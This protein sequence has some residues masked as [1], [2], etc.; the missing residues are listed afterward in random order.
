MNN[1]EKYGTMLVAT[2]GAIAGGL[3]TYNDYNEAEFKK[4]IDLRAATGEFQ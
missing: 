1:I 4:P 3:A 2:I